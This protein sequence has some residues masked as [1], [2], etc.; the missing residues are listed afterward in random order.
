MSLKVGFVRYSKWS[1]TES[2]TGARFG[3]RPRRAPAP[4]F[5]KNSTFPDDGNRRVSV[6]G[7]EAF[8]CCMMN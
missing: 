1:R 8:L 3:V 6:E 4:G 5:E 7:E 2:I